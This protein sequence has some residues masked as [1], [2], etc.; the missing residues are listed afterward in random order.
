MK[1]GFVKWY[2]ST[3]KFGFLTSNDSGGDVYFHITNVK[4]ELVVLLENNKG[5][6]APVV[7]NEKPSAKLSG[8]FEGFDIELDLGKRK[9]GYIHKRDGGFDSDIF[10][11][12]DY[13]SEEEYY[14]HHRNIR[15]SVADKYVSFEE[16]DPVV[17]TPEKTEKGL[18]AKDVLL[19]DTRPFILG[20]ASFQD[21][22]S[23]ILQLLQPGLCE[24]ENWDYIQKPTGSFPILKSYLNKTCER[25]VNQKKTKVGVASDGTEYLFFNT[26]LV[27][28]FQNEIY[29]YFTRNKR[30]SDNQPWG[31][32]IPKW[33]F[34]EF[35]TDQSYYRKYF[36]EAPEIA[37][38]FEETE[39][40]KLIFDTTITIRPNWEHL[41]KRRTRVDS[42]EIQKMTEQEFRD[43]IEDSITMAKKRIKR[44]YKTAIPHFYNNDIQFLVP[45]CE[46]KDRGK[47]L[48][49]MVIQKSEQIYEVTT[50]LTLDQAYN[51]A[52][53]LA[54][55]DREWLNP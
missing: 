7:F 3:K 18:A 29:A 2:D 44:N 21:Y 12:K 40:Q 35:N 19:I 24:D 1:E 43:A 33:W 22:D 46:R 37:T 41:N 20:F 47:A 45:L 10:Y 34:L 28:V 14:L 32:K 27:D 6:D 26:G 9:V 23:A 54:K 16:E 25:V 4:N 42:E 49:A 48:A 30:Y 39:V 8:Q 55:P 52:R 13:Y 38:Y 36:N 53:L 15:K 50:I 31:I 17:F 51:N 5:K 11:I